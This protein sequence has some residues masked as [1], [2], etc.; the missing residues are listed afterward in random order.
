MSKQTFK[1]IEKNFYINRNDSIL[2]KAYANAYLIKAKK[3]IDTFEIANGY[4]LFCNLKIR[5]PKQVLLYADSIIAITK[6]KKYYKYPTRGYLFKGLILYEKNQYSEAL[7]AYLLG[8]EH[9]E[10]HSDSEN[11]VAIKHNIGLL[12]NTI[13]ENEEALKTYL[14]NL[15]FIKKQDTLDKFR[16][17]YVISLFKISGT[18]NRL[19]NI[20]SAHVYVKKAIT[21]TLNGEKQYYYPEILVT[22]GINS[23][24]RKD[25]KTAIDSL[26]KA[27]ELLSSKKNNSSKAVTYLWIGKSLNAMG[28]QDKALVYLKKVDSIMEVSNYSPNVRE[29]FTLLIEH[30]KTVDDKNNQLRLLQKL[31]RFDSIHNKKHNKLNID[32]I[33][34]Y[35]TAKL[36][37]EKNLLIDGIQNKN[38][39]SKY[40]LILIGISVIILLTLFYIYFHKR[41]QAQYQKNYNENLLKIEAKSLNKPKIKELEIAAEVTDDIIKKLKSFE[42][43][44]MFLKSD[45][46]MTKVAKSFKTNSTYLS[47]IINTHK[48]KNFANYVND[49]RIEYCIEQI[50]TNNK[51][52][53][54]TIKSIAKE[55]GFN[56]IQSFSSAFYKKTGQHPS[57]FIK[58]SENQ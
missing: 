46:T 51:F 13:G 31:I 10:S 23:Y 5:K 56:S 39:K 48:N 29:A 25:F 12:K 21:A 43:E 34:N 27:N 8:L 28:K 6:N 40:N 20:D 32:I 47:K 17:H 22:Y 52:R 15:E 19:N 11:V 7:D 49:L 3:L 44:H 4:H 16:P 37:K 18:Y 2:A 57:Y 50:K 42:E 33:K 26:S 24:L 45:L 9:A 55:V 38:E 36:I 14:D 30:Y 53:L 58:N 54:Y 35:D 1:E 41:K